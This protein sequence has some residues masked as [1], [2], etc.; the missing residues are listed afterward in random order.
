MFDLY[1]ERDAHWLWLVCCGIFIGLAYITRYAGLALLPTFVVALMVLLDTWRKRLA[2]M[3]ILVASVLPWMA[4]WGI[5]N[6]IV[7]GNATNRGV[8]LALTWQVRAGVWGL[9]VGEKLVPGN[10]RV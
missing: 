4:G 10:V 1:F 6:E 3:G 7:G 8:E 5:R 2:S 9:Q